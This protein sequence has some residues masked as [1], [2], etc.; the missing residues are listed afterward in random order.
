M[1]VFVRRLWTLLRRE[2]L[3]HFVLL[4]ALLFAAARCASRPER[5]TIVIDR[6]T[7][8]ALVRQQG[9][10]L[11]RPPSDQERALLVQG[12][13]DDAVLLREAYKRGLEQD[14]VV[15][16]H[17]V[18]KMRFILG[19]E[20]A[21]PSEAELRA[22]FEA[23]GERYRS[24]P[25]VTLDH[26]F[27]AD[28]DAVPDGLLEQAAR[29][30]GFPRPGRPPVHARPEARPLQR[31]RSGRPARRRS[32]AP[33]LRA[34]A[35]QLA[36]AVPLRRRR[37]FRPRRGPASGAR[38]RVRGGGRLAA[39]GLAPRPAAA[40]DRRAAGGAARALSDRGRS[41][42]ASRERGRLRLG[43]TIV[44][45]AL[46][47]APGLVAPAAAHDIGVARATLEEQAA[48]RYALEV[49]LGSGAGR[50]VRRP[51]PAG[52]LRRRAGGRRRAPGRGAPALRLPL[53]GRPLE[54]GDVLHLPWQRQG[55][56]V[57]ARWL[58][59]ASARQF[60]TRG[61]AGI[62]VPL[63]A[64]RAGSGSVADAARRYLALG[65]EHILLGIDHLLFVL[66]LL[67]IVRGPWMLIKTVTAFTLA[68]SLTLALATLGLVEVPA[69]RSM[70]RSRSASS[71]SAAEILR[72]R[73][74]RIGLTTRSPG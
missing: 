38:A 7:L 22:Y 47:L 30:G 35:G 23:E 10:I 52:A 31:R 61:G 37:A 46:G 29:R 42:E 74:G 26:V 19:E 60:F 55:A 16:R 56:M 53:P 2:P 27:Y 71:S 9:E 57:A 4:G 51:A 67:L 68:H 20:V 45:L 13:V 18:Q 5:E 64:L 43:W 32:R 21:E 40:D 41:G 66:G 14:A 15:E 49:E 65:V 58:D 50:V 63:A 62:E 25:T 3:V 33:R 17:L 24:P 44:L 28:P 70:P 39:P 73:Q 36:G 8:D 12:M 11:G 72:A 1:P 69:G 48:G 34:A 54:A 59:G 6:P